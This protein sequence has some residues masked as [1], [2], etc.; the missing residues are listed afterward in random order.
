M[1]AALAGATALAAPPADE[2]PHRASGSITVNGQTLEFQGALGVWDADEKTLTVGLYP[3]PLGEREAARVAGDSVQ[4]VASASGGP[5]Q[6]AGSPVAAIILR[7]RKRPKRLA[8]DLVESFSVRVRG[9]TAADQ[10]FGVTRRTRQELAESI[11]ALEGKLKRPAGMIRVA[12]SGSDAMYAG[13]IEWN[14]TAE[15]SVQFRKRR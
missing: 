3:F 1:A 12:S 8:V 7:F 2:P 6:E 4:A 9:L 5:S 15:T 10:T 11:S 13:T 14:F